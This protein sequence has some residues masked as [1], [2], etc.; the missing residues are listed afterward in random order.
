MFGF[1]FKM[2]YKNRHFST[3]FKAKNYQKKWHFWK[4]L[5][6]PSWKLLSGP[7]W[8]RLKNANLDQ[9]ITSKCLARNLFVKQKKGWNPYFYSVFVWQ[10]VFY[11]KKTNLDQIITFKN[12]KL[13]PDNNSTAC[14]YIYIY[15]ERYRQAGRQMRGSR[16]TETQTAERERDRE[17]PSSSSS[18][19]SSSSLSMWMTVLKITIA[20][21]PNRSTSHDFK[22]QNSR[23]RSDAAKSTP[24]PLRMR[25]E[26]A[27]DDSNQNAKG[28]GK[29][30]FRE[31][32]VQNSAFGESM[33]WSPWSL[34]PNYEKP[35]E[36]ASIGRNLLPSIFTRERVNREVQTVNWEVGKEG[37]VE[38]GVKSSLQRAH[39]PWIRGQNGAQTVN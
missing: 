18:S 27:A 29:P 11:K 9:I 22:L 8:V 32:V 37:A 38:T 17:S 2:H 5:S 25:V 6:G 19:S 35:W 23:D 36:T 30:S 34:L 10:S 14:I 16:Q 20:A 4:L 39:K 1:F 21:I 24:Y 15:R 33:L 3:F 13:G 26:V 31:A 7:S 28:A 12:P